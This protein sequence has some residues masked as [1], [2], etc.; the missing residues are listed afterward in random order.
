MEWNDLNDLNDVTRVGHAT[1]TMN[2]AF[3][4]W[5]GWAMI[6]FAGFGDDGS[7]KIWC[8][9]GEEGADV[10]VAGDDD[11]GWFVPG[12]PGVVSVQDKVYPSRM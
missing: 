6:V 2:G 5:C 1:V 8:L 9:E 4:A 11:D 7:R 3:W 12:V 10:G